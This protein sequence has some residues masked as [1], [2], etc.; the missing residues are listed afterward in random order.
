MKRLD[1]FVAAQIVASAYFLS[2]TPL[3]VGLIIAIVFLLLSIFVQR[4]INPWKGVKGFIASL[5]LFTVLVSFIQILF[6]TIP[7]IGQIS[8][9]FT[10][11]VLT[12]ILTAI[13]F[14]SWFFSGTLLQARFDNKKRFLLIKEASKEKIIFVFVAL[15]A[16]LVAAFEY[17]WTFNI[18]I[19]N[20]FRI[21]LI[22]SLV[23]LPSKSFKALIFFALFFSFFE[24][25]S[26]FFLPSGYKDVIPLFLLL[27]IIIFK[28]RQN[29]LF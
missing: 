2:I 1:F 14:V 25:L 28:G 8:N 16:I 27:G 18:S 13:I 12:V 10:L 11:A 4:I 3:F 24:T 29:G 21:G 23:A 19:E 26:V 6:G 15:I 17:L 7:K 9:S 22:G 20:A 5:M